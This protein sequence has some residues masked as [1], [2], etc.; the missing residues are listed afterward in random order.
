MEQLTHVVRQLRML[1]A[2]HQATKIR[3]VC[4]TV[5]LAEQVETAFQYH[6][7][8]QSFA[9]AQDKSAIGSSAICYSVAH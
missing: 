1:S 9:D 6:I 8:L 5:A 7:D 4:R 3:A 2:P